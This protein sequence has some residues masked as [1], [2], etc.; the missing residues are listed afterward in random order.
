SLGAQVRSQIDVLNA[1]VIELTSAVTAYDPN[2]LNLIPQSLAVVGATAKV[3]GATVKTTWL[4]ATSGNFTAAESESVVTTL[5]SL[6]T[7]IQGSLGALGGKY[8]AFKK[9]LQTPIVLLSLKTLKKH[10]G[11]L[12]EALEEKAT[13]QWAAFL[14]LGR[15]L[16]DA[17]FDEAI[18]IYS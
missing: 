12:V 14:P 4:T 8:A 3:D 17:S 10:T 1:S 18:A 5:A 9:T 7:P 2:L 11:E 15:T 6:I 13:A 16:L